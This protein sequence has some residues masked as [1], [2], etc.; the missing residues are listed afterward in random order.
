MDKR[1]FRTYCFTM[2]TLLCI[3][4]VSFMTSVHI[5]RLDNRLKQAEQDS[6]LYEERIQEL[7][8][9]NDNLMGIIIDLEHKVDE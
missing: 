2:F 3:L 1:D 4:V 5:K 9:S 6:V 7:E 8:D